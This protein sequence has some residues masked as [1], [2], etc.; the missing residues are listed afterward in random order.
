MIAKEI[1]QKKVIAVGPDMT[2][3]EAAKLF[4]ESKISGA[5][6]VD[7]A[8]KLMGVLSQT[9]L[10]RHRVRG[11]AGLKDKE[12]SFW[13]PEQAA[14]MAGLTERSSATIKVSEVMTKVVF[15]AP[16]DMPVRDLM[17]MMVREK[18]HRIVITNDG[19]LSGILTTMD[20]LRAVLHWLNRHAQDLED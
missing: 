5:P 2:L 14:G 9:D 10:A 20:M 7:P 19:K 15:S 12:G 3:R 8:G 18:I 4:H 13:V 17:R 6:V 11:L 1:M 16:E